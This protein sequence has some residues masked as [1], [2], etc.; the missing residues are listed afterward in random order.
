MILTNFFGSGTQDEKDAYADNEE[1]P[2]ALTIHSGGL[3][4]LCQITDFLVAPRSVAEG[5]KWFASKPIGSWIP[6]GTETAL[7]T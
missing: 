7:R 2:L 5:R 1:K 6:V 4:I 3:I